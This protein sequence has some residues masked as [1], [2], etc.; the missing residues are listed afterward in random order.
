MMINTAPGLLYVVNRS[1][2]LQDVLEMYK[3]K[4]TELEYP[5]CIEFIDEM[6]VDI[7]GVTIEMF[8][9]F[10]EKCYETMFDGC[11]LLVPMLCPQ[12][13]VSLLPILGRIISHGYLVCGYLPTRIALPCIIGILCGNNATISNSILCDAFLDYISNTERVVFD[14]ALCGD[15]GKKFSPYVEEKLLNT[16]S[17]YGCRQIPTPSNL[18][19]CLLQIARF[20]FVCKPAAAISLMNYGVPKALV[21][22]WLSRSVEGVHSIYKTLT[23]RYLR[24]LI[25][26]L[27]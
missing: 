10:W 9:V 22:F 1:Q 21:Q 4:S 20:E 6:A 8:S 7:G 18:K 14:N 19:S 26:L 27:I 2:V 23:E 24:Y 3:D 17:K 13:D 15:T 12:T 25:F 5:M 11:S 16:L